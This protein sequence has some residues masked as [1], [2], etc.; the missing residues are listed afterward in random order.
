MKRA[1]VII[2]ALAAGLCLRAQSPLESKLEEYLDAIEHLEYE[3]AYPELDFLISSV[4]QDSLRNVVAQKAYCFYRDSKVMGSENLAIYIY[5][6]W[7]ANFKAV[8]DDIALLDEAEFHA[9]LNR[10][11]LIG[12]KAE[13]LELQ[14]LKGRSVSL[15]GKGMSVVFFYSTTCPKCLYISRRLKDILKGRK[16]SLYAVHTGED[17]AQWQA[18]VKRNLSFSKFSKPKIYNLKGGDSDFV[19]A[20]AV[21]QTPR[22]FLVDG[23]GV[24]IGRNLDA[25]ALEILLGRK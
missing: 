8:F 11:S 4:Q 23:D 6:N 3:Q 19:T 2:L 20:Y 17:D 25:A 21:I 15:P 13:K 9:F 18:Y 1:L 16:I 14:D 24:I 22:M 5:D 12:K 7:F 10:R